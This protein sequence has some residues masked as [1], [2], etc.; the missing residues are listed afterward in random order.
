MFPMC[1]ECLRD[2]DMYLRLSGNFLTALMFC[3]MVK[4]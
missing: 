4:L 2:V 3:N 1:D